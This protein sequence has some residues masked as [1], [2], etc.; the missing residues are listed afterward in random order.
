MT[1]LLEIQN[2]LK[3]HK[4]INPLMALE[5]YGCMRLAAR[6]Q[7]LRSMGMKIETQIRKGNGKAYASYRLEEK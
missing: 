6:I 3:E 2:H 7:E 4:E 5:R 1:Q